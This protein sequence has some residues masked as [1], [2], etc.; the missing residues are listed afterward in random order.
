MNRFCNPNSE[1]SVSLA[2][3]ESVF[4]CD[5]RLFERIGIP[6]S[7]IICAMRHKHMNVFP[8]SLIRKRWTKSAKDDHIS[9]VSF[10]ES[11]YEKLLMF[12]RSSVCAAFNRLCDVSRK[13]YGSYK[14]A[15]FD[16]SCKVY[17]P[18][19]ECYLF[20]NVMKHGSVF[21]NSTVKMEN[22]LYYNCKY[23]V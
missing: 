20:Q 5:C 11:D 1:F 17:L 2:K 21:D 22:L 6:C 16:H 10:E 23:L 13:D 15:V 3:M 19:C 9:S 12:R 14:E 8:E 18:F 7:H 4:L